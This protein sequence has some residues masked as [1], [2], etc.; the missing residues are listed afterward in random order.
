MDHRNE[1]LVF[2]WKFIPSGC[3]KSSE[4]KWLD[5]CSWDYLSENF[6]LYERDRRALALGYDV[7]YVDPDYNVHIFQRVYNNALKTV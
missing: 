1:D 5:N 2:R 4:W 6:P 3:T 7:T